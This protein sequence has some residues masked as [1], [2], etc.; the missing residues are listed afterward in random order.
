ML[1]AK[2]RPK[3]LS[4]WISRFRGFKYWHKYTDAQIEAVVDLLKLWE[5]RYGIDIS[6]NE[7]IWDVTPRALSGENGVFTHCSV[8]KD[9]FDVFPQPE[10]IEA[11]KSL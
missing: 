6:Y 2:L 7:D 3:T 1:I 4:H 11:L 8:R 5:K 9:K 10:L